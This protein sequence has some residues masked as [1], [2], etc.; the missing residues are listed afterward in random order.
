[1]TSAP[2]ST[3]GGVIDCATF[4]QAAAAEF[5]LPHRAAVWRC[6]RLTLVL[7]VTAQSHTQT[8][9][10]NSC[11]S[12]ALTS[13]AGWLAGCLPTQLMKLRARCLHNA[14]VFLQHMR[15]DSE[16]T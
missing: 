9:L 5:V 12:A 8:L 11:C 3:Y 16:A 14:V 4:E 13:R 2:V 15:G 6:F 10:T 7:V 1:M